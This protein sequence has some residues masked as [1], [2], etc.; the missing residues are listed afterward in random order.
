MHHLVLEQV[1]EHPAVRGG[2]GYAP[3]RGTGCKGHAR[4]HRRASVRYCLVN[5][6]RCCCQMP[7]CLG[8]RIRRTVTTPPPATIR[9]M[10][11]LN[12]AAHINLVA[13][14][15]Y[16]SCELCTA[17]SVVATTTVVVTHPR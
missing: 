16:T 13:G 7:S 6:I 14:N 15:K 1:G 3:Y 11:M 2:R 12:E 5:A 17:Q 4:L 10:S 9:E 8:P